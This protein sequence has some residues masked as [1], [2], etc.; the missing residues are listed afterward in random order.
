MVV[1][2]AGNEEEGSNERGLPVPV[3]TN[4]NNNNNYRVVVV[5]PVEQVVVTLLC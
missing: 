2:V 5:G 1:S 3:Q 4:N